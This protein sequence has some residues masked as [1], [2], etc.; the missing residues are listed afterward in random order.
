MLSTNSCHILEMPN[1]KLKTMK[2]TLVLFFALFTSIVCFS[3][4][5]VT[6]H[7]GQTAE[8]TVTEVTGKAIKFIYKG[9]QAVNVI[10]RNAIAEIKHS[11]GRVEQM[12]SKVNV[13][14]P[15]DWKN[16][17]VVNDKEEVLGLKFIRQIEKHS[18]GTFSF[19]LTGGHFS[20]KVLNKMRKEAAK[21][22]GCIVLVLS[23]ESTGKCKINGNV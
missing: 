13:A 12:S 8:G 17:R 21:C 4:D 5:V 15:K 6:F 2:K 9:E 22:G 3:Q 1:L 20:E 7:N 11:N 19:S 23:A 10:G 16:V 14:S 18:S